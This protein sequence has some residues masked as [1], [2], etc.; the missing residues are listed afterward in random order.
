MWVRLATVTDFLYCDQPLVKYRQH[1]W[2]MS[3]DP[4]LLERDS[5]RVLQ[6]GFSLPGVPPALCGR[7]FAAFGQNYMVLAGCYYHASRYRD[8]LRCAV[9]A[10]LLDVM[11]FGYIAAYPLRA[12]GRL[13][14]GG[15]PVGQW[16]SG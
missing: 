10:M 8:F 9:R 1:G 2:N 7:R 11:Q 15:R 12:G 3:R 5:L 6:K 4:E 13:W 16:R 14:R